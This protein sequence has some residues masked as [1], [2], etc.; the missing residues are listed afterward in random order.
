MVVSK[1][2]DWSQEEVMTDF[3]VNERGD[4]V[5]ATGP[6]KNKQAG[7]EDVD[8]YILIRYKGHLVRAHNLVWLRQH[9]LWPSFEIDHINN[10]PSDNTINNLREADRFLNG[11]NQKLQKR[12]AG[13]FKGVHKNG[14]SYRVKIKKFGKQHNIGTFSS[15]FE[16]AMMYNFWAEKLFGEFANFNLV[17]EDAHGKDT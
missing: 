5:W 12:R 17:F 3:S 15:E 16:A 8:G 11:A 9:G 6:N 13:K 10:N 2:R 7:W 1:Q 14:N 4:L